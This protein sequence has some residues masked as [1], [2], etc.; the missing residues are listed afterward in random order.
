MPQ[1]IVLGPVL[2]VIFINDL[3]E[4]IHKKEGLQEDLN[5]MCDWSDTWQLLFNV[6][7]C[8]VIHYG[9]KQPGVYLLNEVQ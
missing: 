7:K 2:F 9:K 1:G 8:K 4:V 3:P 6:G 5:S